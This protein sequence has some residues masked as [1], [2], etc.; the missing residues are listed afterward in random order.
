MSDLANVYQL[1]RSKFEDNDFQYYYPPSYI[2]S[3]TECDD[4][5]IF[6]FRKV[7]RLFAVRK[8]KD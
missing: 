8:I 3:L 2:R 4:K 5:I 6:A 1:F 7:R